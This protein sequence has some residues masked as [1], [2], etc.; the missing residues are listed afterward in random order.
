MANVE[1]LDSEK[2]EADDAGFE[3]QA[4]PSVLN[5]LAPAECTAEESDEDSS[6]R[7]E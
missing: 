7:D 1:C 2:T 4:E 5:I 3:A 6:E